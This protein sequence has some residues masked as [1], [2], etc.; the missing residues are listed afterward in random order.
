M[1]IRFVLLSFP[2]LPLLFRNRWYLS[3]QP[4]LGSWLMGPSSWASS[5][6]LA[7]PHLLQIANKKCFYLLCLEERGDMG[8]EMGEGA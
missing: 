4:A 5:L 8:D 7:Q 1:T 6:H 3:K 2:S